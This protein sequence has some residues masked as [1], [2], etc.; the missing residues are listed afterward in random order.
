M[1]VSTVQGTGL[2]GSAACRSAGSRAPVVET[3]ITGVTKVKLMSA[4]FFTSV[5]VRRTLTPPSQSRPLAGGARG[6]EH[7][8]DG[9]GR[10]HPRAVVEG[11]SAHA[12]GRLGLC[13]LALSHLARWPRA[14]IGLE[15]VLGDGAGRR[16]RRR[17]HP[18]RYPVCSVGG[19]ERRE[20]AERGPEQ[21][22]RRIAE[23]PH[24]IPG[25]GG[26]ARDAHA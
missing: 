15:R 3:S 19:G 16:T 14:R 23:A 12:I 24:G 25:G 17:G 9:V 18:I 4:N 22:P 11:G 8:I 26:P 7:G 20:I 1:R 21:A 2:Q 10:G 6:E 5:S 13:R